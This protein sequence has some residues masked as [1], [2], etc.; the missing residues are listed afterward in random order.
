M[1]TVLAFVPSILGL[2]L[3]GLLVTS[4]RGDGPSWSLD[5]KS[6]ST[7]LK[8]YWTP[9]FLLVAPLAF[10][11]N[12]LAMAV[13]A[14]LVLG[15]W[16]V[17]LVRWVIGVLLW[18][19]NKGFLW[20]WKHVI[21]TP[22]VLVAKVVWHYVMVW[23]WRIY[24]TT[25]FAVRDSFTREGMRVGALCMTMVAASVGL[26]HWLSSWL[27]NPMFLFLGV[28][29]AEV[30]Y[31]WGMGVLGSM[32]ESG[33]LEGKQ[34]EQHRLVGLRTARLGMKYVGAAAAAVVL[35]FLS[36]FSGAVADAGYL[37]LGVFINAAHAAA[38]LGIGVCLVLFLSLAVLPAYVL[39]GHDESPLE[40]MLT[41]I[42]NGRDSM[43][44]VILGAVPGAVF[45]AFVALIPVALVGGAYMGTM[46]LKEMALASPAMNA[47]EEA[48]EIEATIGDSFAE[49]AE[50]SAAVKAKP[51]VQ[52]KQAQL[53][54]LMEF[55]QNLIDDPSGALEGVETVDYSSMRAAMEADYASRQAMR[56]GRLGDLET[57]M[58]VLQEQIQLELDER[59]TY[60]V[61]RSDDKGETWSVV[62]EGLE[63]AG[64]VDNG[65]AAGEGY[66]YRVTARNRKGS[67]G[68]G[69]VT[70]AFTRSADISGPSGISVGTEG[71]FRVVLSWNDNDWNEEGIRVE[72]SYDGKD[73][74]TLAQLDANS[75]FYVDESVQDTTYRYR[76]ISFRGEDESEPS[77]TYRSV[78]PSLPSPRAR[79]KAANSSSALVV[80]SHDA[81]YDRLN[82]GGSSEN[83]DGAP[84]VFN[85]LSRLEEL[86]ARLAEVSAQRD[87][88]LAE[89]EV[90]AANTQPRLDLLASL[91]AE[92]AASS[93][94]RIVT[95]LLG[96]L[97]LALLVGGATCTLT[98]YLGGMNQQLVRLTDGANFYFVEQV[99]AAR[100]EE[101]NQ[102]LLGFLLLVLTGAPMAALVASVV[103][104]ALTMLT[105]LTM[106]FSMPA[107]PTLDF[108][109]PRM[110]MS[111]VPEWGA[112]TAPALTADTGAM[113]IAEGDAAEEVGNTYTLRGGY[114]S[115]WR[116]IVTN[117]GEDRYGEIRAANA[118]L[119]EREW[120]GLSAGDII[121][122]P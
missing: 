62:A 77:T 42:R 113:S 115:V 48:A 82:R 104:T 119:T 105:G 91:P 74:S 121:K 78:Q 110:D 38:V 51:G 28:L 45:G 32:R 52:R 84:L 12:V 68:P 117:F 46:A 16:L 54:Y 99:R 57:E 72:R 66:Q 8:G 70:A 76:V 88:L 71:N 33:D 18:V 53:D 97:A 15:E 4:Y 6:F 25:Y 89:A 118:E 37:L 79:V 67:S 36:S 61:E 73:W 50:W 3:L 107:L 58:A 98:S 87:Q 47:A 49:F 9:L 44:K 21:V 31:L 63:R 17:A 1:N 22:V 30:P 35:I 13:H 120:A 23:P 59:S 86:Q 100:D 2:A 83:G 27:E 108:S 26:G 85:G 19:W 122:L 41:L 60:T 95:F 109:M 43:L 116:E 92:E 94:M 111:F 81:D 24:K 39:D 96:M 11:Y 29:L 93:G 90:D 40:E 102:P 112:A 80:W 55:P 75:T 7:K 101:G 65:L 114:L 106:L 56:A 64:Y 5:F 69:N 34:R 20:Y 14:V 10:V 103:G